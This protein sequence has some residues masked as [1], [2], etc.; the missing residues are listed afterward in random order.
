MGTVLDDKG[1]GE[2]KARDT[3]ELEDRPERAILLV[4]WGKKGTLAAERAAERLPQGLQY[5]VFIASDFRLS[6]QSEARRIEVEFTMPSSLRKAEAISHYAPTGYKSIIYLDS[7]VTIFEDCSFLF[8][9]AEKHGLA[10]SIAP[11]YS[12]DEYRNFGEVMTREGVE[13][14]GQLQ[15]QAGVIV[16]THKPKV[17]QVFEKWIELGRKHTDIWVRDQPHLSLAMEVVGFQPYVFSKN[18]NLRGTYEPVI[19]RV[20][21][22]HS[23]APVPENLN[24]YESAHP[25][26]L[27]AKYRL[28]ALKPREY[29]S[30]FW[31]WAFRRHCVDP[32]YKKFRW[33]IPFLSGPGFFTRSK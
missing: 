16:F 22:W 6:P 8:E 33:A 7:D 28:R 23:N 25:P 9:K 24:S 18:Y 31:K 17:K 30:D 11:T 2:V 1:C 19:G 15:Y 32:V 10:L 21:G 3:S 13:H 26:R 14:H 5:D 4:G 27:L 12:L 20:R 29:R